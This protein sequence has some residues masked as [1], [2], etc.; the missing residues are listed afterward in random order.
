MKRLPTLIVLSLPLCVLFCLSFS[1]GAGL[2]NPQKIRVLT[3]NLYNRP[4]ER[5]ARLENVRR[6][7]VEQN[8]DLVALQEVSTGWLL[9]GDPMKIFSGIFPGFFSAREWH[10][11]N[12]GIFQTGLG[13]WSRWPLSD[14]QYTEFN[15]HPFWDAKGFY[16]ARVEIPGQSLLWFN[17]HLASTHDQKMQQQELDQLAA[18]I[19]EARRE[20]RTE[21]R[22]EGRKHAPDMPVLITG[23]WNIEWK[24]PMLQSWLKKMGADSLYA[25]L[26]ENKT[27]VTWSPDYTKTCAFAG[28]KEGEPGEVIDH[29]VWIQSKPSLKWTSGRIGVSPLIPHPSDHCYVESVFEF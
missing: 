25:H 27:H 3:W 2:E 19:T 14:I 4:W 26:P 15:N 1:S 10:E 21:D 11:S 8:S 22:T 17:V 24:S 16:Q 13:L 28:E 9:P 5:A 23:D 18:A 6:T 7:L 20:A 12:A 29:I